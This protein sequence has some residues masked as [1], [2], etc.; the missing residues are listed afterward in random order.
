MDPSKKIYLA[1]WRQLKLFVEEQGLDWT[2]SSF[3]GESEAIVKVGSPKH[4]IGLSLIGADSKNPRPLISAGFWIPDSREAFALLKAKRAEIEA[5]MGKSLVWDSKPGR[6]SCWVRVTVGL[7]LSN[8]KNW[9]ASFE[10][11][12]ENAGKIRDVCDKALAG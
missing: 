10:W 8:E 3:E 2:F 9:P 6:K 1:Y 5:E 12:A 7:D 4:R 11:F